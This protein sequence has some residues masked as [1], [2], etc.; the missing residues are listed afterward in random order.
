[1]A[2]V[3]R[4]GDTTV[5]AVGGDVESLHARAR[6]TTVDRAPSAIRTGVILRL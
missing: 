5:A 2:V 1:M 4:T 6:T 3:A